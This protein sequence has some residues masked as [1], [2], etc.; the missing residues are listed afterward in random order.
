[1]NTKIYINSELI[2]ITDDVSIPLT[3]AIADV[4]E[5]EKRNTT[6]SKTVVIP[7]SQLNNKLFGQI[8]NVNSSV[9]SSGTTNFNPSFNPNLKA[10]AIIT[11]KDVVQF[12]GIVQLL[13]VNLLDEYEIIMRL[14]S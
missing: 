3:Y 1:M 7:G 11:Y 9:N 8:W 2:D 5:P 12:T 14:L 10:S 13:N 6:F 4:R